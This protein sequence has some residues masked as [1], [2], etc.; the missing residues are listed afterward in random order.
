MLGL[1]KMM[2]TNG[3]TND[4]TYEAVL[5]I[6]PGLYAEVLVLALMLEQLIVLTAGE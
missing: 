5:G 1:G 6:L 4:N 3:S 2:L